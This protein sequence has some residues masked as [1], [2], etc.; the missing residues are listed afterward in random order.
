M[1]HARKTSM[2]EVRLANHNALSVS[3]C[4]FFALCSIVGSCS[5][6]NFHLSTF[7]VSR[8]HA[9]ILSCYSNWVLCL[10]AFSTLP[11]YL[12]VIEPSRARGP[13]WPYCSSKGAREW[14]VTKE[15]NRQQFIS[16]LVALAC[17]CGQWPLRTQR[18][19]PLCWKKGQRC[20][21]VSLQTIEQLAEKTVRPG[22]LLDSTGAARASRLSV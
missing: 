12:S 5:R 3:A 19:V 2:S 7:T 17:H 21:G 8:R 15:E 14:K 6:G 22:T 9:F 20:Q 1:T 13:L 10:A 18:W 16:V 4:L 11:F